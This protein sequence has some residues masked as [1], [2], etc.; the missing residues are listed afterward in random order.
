MVS[1]IGG[2]YPDMD[3]IDRKICN[4]LQ[5]DGRASSSEIAAAVGL[6]VSS[7]NERVR[8]LAASGVIKAWRGVLAPER[9]GAATCAFLLIDMTF[10]GEMYA[11]QQLCARPE[12]Q[13]LHHISGPHSY[14][15]K[16]RL[17]DTATMQ[18][19]LQDVVKPLAAV[20][21]TETSFSMDTVKETTEILIASAEKDASRCQA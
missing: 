20:V 13:D 21:R 5:Q 1:I 7:A 16:I 2:I 11:V 19:F 4:I 10:E 14:L 8:R 3:V 15:A 18:C 12:V 6:S 17:A 9:V